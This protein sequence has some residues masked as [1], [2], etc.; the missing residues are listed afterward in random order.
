VPLERL[1]AL[2]EMLQFLQGQSTLG[3]SDI[4]QIEADS[5]DACL[6]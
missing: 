6:V 3:I 2:G 4:N 5:S 1:Y